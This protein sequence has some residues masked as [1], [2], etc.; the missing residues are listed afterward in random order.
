MTTSRPP[1]RS[2]FRLCSSA[3]RSASISPFTSMRNAW[4]IFVRYLASSLRGVHGRTASTRSAV[5]ARGRRARARS[6]QL[7]AF[8]GVST[9]PQSRSRRVSSAFE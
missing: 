4:K 2:T 8:H 3:M 7:A 1:G 6:M 5:V 9:S